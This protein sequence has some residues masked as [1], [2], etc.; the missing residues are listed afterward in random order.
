[1]EPIS[2]TLILLLNQGVTDEEC[3]EVLYQ[4]YPAELIQE[5]ANYKT[6]FN[7]KLDVMGRIQYLAKENEDELIRNHRRDRSMKTVY[8]KCGDSW[9]ESDNYSPMLDR[10]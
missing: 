6:T 8:E 3:R 9:C 1:M 5:L 10:E 2:L 7:C 4:T